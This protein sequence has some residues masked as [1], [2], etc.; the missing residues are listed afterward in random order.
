MWCPGDCPLGWSVEQGSMFFMCLQQW[1]LGLKLSNPIKHLGG[2]GP[3]KENKSVLNQTF[4]L[5]NVFQWR[6]LGALALPGSRI[7]LLKA[8]LEI[9]ENTTT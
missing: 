2:W 1:L 3:P 5:E 6:D 4:Y 8:R 7:L 9:S